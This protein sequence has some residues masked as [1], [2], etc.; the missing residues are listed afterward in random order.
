MLSKIIHRYFF[1]VTFFYC[2]SVG[3]LFS[4]DRG[5]VFLEICK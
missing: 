5:L 4:V 1:L 3:A 2:F